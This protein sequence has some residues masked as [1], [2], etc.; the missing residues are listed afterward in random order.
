M[1]CYSDGESPD[2]DGEEAIIS[3]LSLL[4]ALEKADCFFFKPPELHD[5]L[6]IVG[7]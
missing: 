4:V 6:E 5:N 7:C 3:D 2:D 1:L